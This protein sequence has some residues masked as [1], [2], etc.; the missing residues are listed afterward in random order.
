MESETE[1][2]QK[3]ER[4][5]LIPTD[6]VFK[7]K[8]MHDFTIEHPKVTHLH[9][10]KDAVIYFSTLLLFFLFI[11]TDNVFGI[12]KSNNLLEGL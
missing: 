7:R 9:A 12:N 2:T 4:K 3:Y 10:F 8:L 5:K 1:V 11:E 6:F